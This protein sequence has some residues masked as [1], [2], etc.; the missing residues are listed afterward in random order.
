M[1]PAWGLSTQAKEL[2]AAI[3]VIQS[4]SNE[5][6]TLLSDSAKSKQ[7]K[8]N[9]KCVIIPELT[10]VTEMAEQLDTKSSLKLSGLRSQLEASCVFSPTEELR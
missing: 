6:S 7:T 9:T 1:L 2:I 8:A 4:S 10:D 5:L 3:R